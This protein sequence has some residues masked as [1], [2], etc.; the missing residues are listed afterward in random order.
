MKKI[1]F[2]ILFITSLFVF[3]SCNQNN[4]KQSKEE[5]VTEFVS[6]LTEADTT[7]MLDACDN[8]MKMLQDGKIDE[9]MNVLYEYDDS[10]N[11]VNPL[12]ESTVQ[13][14]RRVFTMF[15]VIDYVR[16][17]YSFQLEGLNDVKYSVK[18]T[19]DNEETGEKGAQ[20]TF[21]FNPVKV[22]GSWYVTVKRA[23]QELD[24]SRL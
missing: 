23:D 18:F 15:P 2:L 16:Q 4:K 19:P 1:L 5:Q 10:L 6:Q 22:D 12:S 24:N 21:M 13:R 9:V 11:Q 20:T 8:C 14:Y 3:V 7:A 17:Y